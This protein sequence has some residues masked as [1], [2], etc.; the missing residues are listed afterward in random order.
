MTTLIPSE[1]VV[2]YI[3]GGPSWSG[4][5]FRL[6]GKQQDSSDGLKLFI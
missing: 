6:T 4:L 5:C 3:R 2:I 1:P